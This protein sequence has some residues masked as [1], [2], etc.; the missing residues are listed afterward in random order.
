[1][2]GSDERH[3]TMNA[4]IQIQIQL[5]PRYESALRGKLRRLP[6]VHRATAI[7]VHKRAQT[8]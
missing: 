2:I 1:M 8:G 7:I 3:S 5:L 4:Q 6:I